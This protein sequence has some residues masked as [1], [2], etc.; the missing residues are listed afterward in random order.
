MLIKWKTLGKKLK[1]FK[2]E[3]TKRKMGQQTRET[4]EKF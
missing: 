3:L 2:S 4:G 1:K